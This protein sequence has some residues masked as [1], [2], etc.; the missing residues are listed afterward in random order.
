MNDKEIIY[1]KKS[2]LNPIEVTKFLSLEPEGKTE[3]HLNNESA[4]SSIYPKEDFTKLDYW[5]FSCIM[6]LIT[7]IKTVLLLG[8][9]AG[10]IYA[11]MS[12]IYKDINFDA[13]EIDPEIVEAGYG[14]SGLKQSTNLRIF[15]QDTR[16][17]LEST[18]NFYDLIII[19][20]FKGRETPYYLCTYDFFRLA[21]NHLNKK[22]IL[23]LN[24]AYNKQYIRN[25]AKTIN[26]AFPSVFYI[27]HSS[28]IFAF[29]RRTFLFFLRRR[30]RRVKHAVVLSVIKE[31]TI[32]QIKKFKWKMV[33][34]LIFDKKS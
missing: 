9:G 34:K 27:N 16:Q 8:L 2:I 28:V 21:Y 6:P 3:L 13:V 18:G 33:G 1:G 11:K 12:H 20:V 19:D 10:T 17:F 7:D 30:L 25:I 14:Y 29:K 32:L 26:R 22:G 23:F 24:F 15:I 5:T 31:W 4:I